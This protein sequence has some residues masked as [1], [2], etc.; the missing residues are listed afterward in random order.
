M[1]NARL[2]VRIAILLIVGVCV[3]E[4][5]RDVA[6]IWSAEARS[7]DGNWLA[8]ANTEQHGGPG[9]AGVETIVYL[10][11]TNVSRLPAAVLSFFHDPSMPSQSGKTIN[12]TMKWATPTHLEVTYD[13]HADLGLQVVK[14]SGIDI[15]VRNLSSGTTNTSQQGSGGRE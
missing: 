15:S 6:T 12:L 8:S 7:P 5:C 10:K 2:A 9:T 13:G 11:Q 14:Y 4:G 1:E 3:L